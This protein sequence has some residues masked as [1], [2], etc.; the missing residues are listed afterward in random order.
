MSR[1]YKKNPGYTDHSKSTYK[2]KRF[3]NKKV[4]KTKNISNGG[5]YRKV[6]ESW[7]ICD[8]KFIFFDNTYK[9]LFGNWAKLTYK[10]FIK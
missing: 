2:D 9:D 1:S 5:A 10:D 3:A 8:F 6:Y 7:N 4:R